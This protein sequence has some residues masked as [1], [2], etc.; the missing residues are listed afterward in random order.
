MGI[1]NTQNI[2]SK[3]PKERML[4]RQ[5]FAFVRAFVNSDGGLAQVYKTN[6]SDTRKEELY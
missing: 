6:Q 4:S 5:G 3:S 1:V 2:Y